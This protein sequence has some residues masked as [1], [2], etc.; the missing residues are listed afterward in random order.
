MKSF[1]QPAWPFAAALQGAENRRRCHP[2]RSRD[3]LFSYEAKE[4]SRF[5]GLNSPSE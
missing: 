2:E 5:L 1:R 3:L 4:K